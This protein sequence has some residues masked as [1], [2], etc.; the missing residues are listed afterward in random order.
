MPTGCDGGISQEK[1]ALKGVVCGDDDPAQR[2]GG[3]VHSHE[4]LGRSDVELVVLGAPLLPLEFYRRQYRHFTY[5][6]ARSF[7]WVQEMMLSCDVLVLPSVVEG[8]AMVQMEAMS[9]G[10]PLVVTPNA[11][12]E[13]LVEE[14]RTGFL[15]PIRA[16]EVLAERINWIADHR[17]W[18]GDMRSGILEKARQSN[19]HFYSEKVLSVLL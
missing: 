12:A 15:V 5:E 7:R 18:A 19:W 9:C 1:R 8:R 17:D 14:G 6:P 13:D 10:L 4:R 16:P 3:S 11:G 2:A